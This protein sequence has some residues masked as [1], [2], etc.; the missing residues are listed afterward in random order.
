MHIT[1]DVA[2]IDEDLLAHEEH[3]KYRY[4]QFLQTK[5]ALED[6][7][8]SLKEFAKVSILVFT[9]STWCKEAVDTYT[10][11]IIDL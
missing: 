1:Q 3:L 5:K 7:E 6:A 2:D 8:G 10:G 4:K 9:D 11:H